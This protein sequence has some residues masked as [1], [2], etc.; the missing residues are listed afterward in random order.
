MERR[1][2]TVNIDQA[3]AIAKSGISRATS[4]MGI[5]VNAA[6]DPNFKSYQL[7]HLTNL[8]TLPDNLS[9]DQIEEIKSNFKIWVEHGGIREMVESFTIFLDELFKICDLVH[10]F[11]SGKPIPDR[12][13]QYLRFTKQGLPNKLNI[14]RQRF[15]VT[16][17]Y[18]EFVCSINDV[19]NCI[20]H[21][22]GVVQS[23]DLKGNEALQV[24][25]R[26]IDIWIQTGEGQKIA[27]NSPLGQP[28][29]I[30]EG[31]QLVVEQVNRKKDFSEGQQIQFE[32]RELSE[33][34]W[35]FI[36]ALHQ[37]Y[38]SSLEYYRRKGV[39]ISDTASAVKK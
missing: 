9:D 32:T 11:K 33:V 29:D 38:E 22:R 35:T 19:R 4:F 6:I 20:T 3:F 34:V 2:F 8:Q 15:G 13:Q 26:G 24:K 37:V 23:E 39:T 21:R 30:G 31:D 36:N 18:F 12:T 5:G 28:H 10:V 7:S 27:M 16:F 14:L 17:E 25:W 1:V